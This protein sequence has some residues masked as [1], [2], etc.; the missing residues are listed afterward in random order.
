[1]KAAAFA[2][3]AVFL[4]APASAKHWHDDGRHWKKHAKHHGDDDER[5]DHHRDGCGLEPHDV[6]I[7]SEYY[8]P[9]DHRLPPGLQKKLRRTGHLPPGWERRFEP[10]PVVVERQLVPVPVGYRRGI[11]D[12]SVV[13]YD[14]R[15]NVMIDVAVLFGG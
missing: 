3:L 5:F 8:A 6:R 9:R 1:M 13:V 12:G 2:L 14:T 15:T 10:L 11:L 4:A 7:I